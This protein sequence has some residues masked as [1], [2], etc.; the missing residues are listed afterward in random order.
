M[1]RRRRDV[2]GL[3]ST[4]EG[5]REIRDDHRVAGECPVAEKAPRRELRICDRREVDI[6]ARAPERGRSRAP[7]GRDVGGALAP[8]RAGRRGR[9]RPRQAPDRPALLVP[10]PSAMACRLRRMRLSTAL[11]TAASCADDDQ[12]WPLK[13]TPSH[14]AVAHV[15][16]QRRLWRRRDRAHHDAADEPME[17]GEQP[18]PARRAPESAR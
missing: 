11:L 10:P 8:E 13:I 17:A 16:E 18:T 5:S 4:H 7:L 14:V 3:Q 12:R 1:L 6:D 2:P 15:R 9:L